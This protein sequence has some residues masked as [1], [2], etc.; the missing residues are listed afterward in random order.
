MKF[1]FDKIMEVTIGELLNGCV[2]NFVYI[3]FPTLLLTTSCN[4]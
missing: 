2:Q 3:P 1:Q 4:K